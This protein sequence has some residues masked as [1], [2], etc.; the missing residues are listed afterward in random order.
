MIY[1]NLGV[2]E[3][4]RNLF[5]R[6]LLV[7]YTV[8]MP[9]KSVCLRGEKDIDTDVTELYRYILLYLAAF[10]GNKKNDLGEHRKI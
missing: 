2:C 7:S 6:S 9:D 8:G 5:I 3:F 1:S 4:I 10:K